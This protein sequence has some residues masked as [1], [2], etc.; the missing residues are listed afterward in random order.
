M[1]LFI[2]NLDLKLSVSEGQSIVDAVRQRFPRHQM[3]GCLGGGCGVCRVQIESGEYTTGRMSSEHITKPGIH[4]PILLGCRVYP[5]SDM[6]ITYI[7]KGEQQ[8]H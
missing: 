7:G 3:V 2:Q 6:I 4:P 5:Q 8:W 1:N